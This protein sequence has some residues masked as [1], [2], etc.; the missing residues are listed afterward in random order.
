MTSETLVNIDQTTQRNNPEDRNLHIF[1]R[2]DDGGSMTSETLVNIDQT[3]Q[4]NNPEDGY[5]HKYFIRGQILNPRI[6]CI[7]PSRGLSRNVMQ[8]I[9][10]ISKNSG[11]SLT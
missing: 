9:R 3:T 2:P 11:A 6:N 5:L 10:L 1:N 4:R 8:S 7:E